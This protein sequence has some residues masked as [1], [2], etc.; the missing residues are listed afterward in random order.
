MKTLSFLA[1]LAIVSA[2]F[3]AVLSRGED[4]ASTLSKISNYRQWTRV[5]E[6]PVKVQ[7]PLT[8]LVTSQE[9]DS[10]R[11]AAMS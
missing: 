2:S 10:L 4:D 1:S 7:L 11:S 5:N 6:E 8:T 3:G 9:I